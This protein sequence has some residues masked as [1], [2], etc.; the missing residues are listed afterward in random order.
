MTFKK[1]AQSL[2]TEKTDNKNM[3]N[4]DIRQILT[5]NI[6]QKIVTLR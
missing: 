6:N 1:Y 3:E 4:R 5:S 2:R